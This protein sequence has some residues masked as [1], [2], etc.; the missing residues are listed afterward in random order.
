MLQVARLSPRLLGEAAANVEAYLSG[1]RTALGA[2]RN[3][4]GDADLYYT[5][6]GL[7]ALAALRTGPAAAGSDEDR[8]TAAYLAGFGG[9]AGLDLVHLACL[10]RARAAVGDRDRVA[11]ALLASRIEALRRDDG[12]WAM[13]AGD[14]ASTTYGTFLAVA[15]FQ[16]LGGAPAD[17]AAAARYL[18]ST[19]LTGGGYALDA[20]T[21]VATTPTTAAAVVALR[22]LGEGAAPRTAA[23]L[24]ARHHPEG[25]FVAAEGGTM[26]DLLSTAVALHALSVLDS[27]CADLAE[28]LLDFVDSLWTARGAF[29]AHWAED[30]TDC[31]YT[32]YGLL[33]LGHLAV[34]QA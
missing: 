22:Q 23:W 31:E 24:R 9:G 10:A 4:A 13:S 2:F 15:A 29:Y 5:V 34:W 32:F 14:S 8:R 20:T 21:P 7:D 12:G 33:A 3:R 1:E 11:G 27:P 26:P 18:A 25:G 16:D 28:P 17:P 30:A 19:A 6:F